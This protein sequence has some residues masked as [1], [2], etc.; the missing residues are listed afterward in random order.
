[1]LSKPMK[2]KTRKLPPLNGCECYFCGSTYN[3]NQHE[4]W[5]GRNREISIYYGMYVNLCFSCHRAL[6]DG[7]IND[8]ELREYGKVKFAEMYP[9]LD[10]KDIFK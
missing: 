8:L 7:K 3:L 6:H 9:G 5:F 2:S 1:M 10:W 4:I